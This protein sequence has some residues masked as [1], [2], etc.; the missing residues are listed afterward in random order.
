M[1]LPLRSDLTVYC[2][3]VW[4]DQFVWKGADGVPVPLAG[5]SARMDIRDAG[6][7][8][9]DPAGTA[10]LK[11]TSGG[12]TIVL[13]ASDGTVTLAVPAATT[14]TLAPTVGGAEYV[15]DLELVSGAGEVRKLAY[16]RVRVVA[17]VTR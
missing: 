7:V 8:S 9:P 4:D 11:L 14:A 5:W 3:G 17:E 16:G 1:S 6:D 12:G 10:R 15:Y 13:G 2:G